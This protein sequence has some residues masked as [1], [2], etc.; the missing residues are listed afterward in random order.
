MC[1]EKCVFVQAEKQILRVHHG[2][3]R[4][5]FPIDS[6]GRALDKWTMDRNREYRQQAQ[7]IILWKRQHPTLRVSFQIDRAVRLPRTTSVENSDF[8][9]IVN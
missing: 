6:N 1:Y 8:N 5:I 2:G 7:R 9:F 3:W 4:R